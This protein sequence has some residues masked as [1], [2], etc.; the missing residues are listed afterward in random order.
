[1]RLKSLILTLVVFHSYSIYSQKQSDSELPT[2]LHFSNHMV[3]F[4][5]RNFFT[6]IQNASKE[7]RSC[8]I[9]KCT[10]N[11]EEEFANKLW[12]PFISK[13][14][15][16]SWKCDHAVFVSILNLRDD[17]EKIK[18]L[19]KR[20]RYCDVLNDKFQDYVYKEC[21]QKLNHRRFICNNLKKITKDNSLRKS[22]LRNLSSY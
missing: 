18:P 22:N 7:I 17:V 19:V 14:N 12:A 15:E 20:M 8:V 10:L 6:E 9:E 4:H 2:E 5:K 11:E 16:M 21:L 13:I 3:D 1:M